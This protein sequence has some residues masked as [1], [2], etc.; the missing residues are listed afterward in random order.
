MYPIIHFFINEVYVG[1]R[2]IET[3][4]TH[5]KLLNNLDVRETYTTEV[6]SIAINVYEQSNQSKHITDFIYAISNVRDAMSL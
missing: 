1:L 6:V 2:C 5:V 4:V 3:Y